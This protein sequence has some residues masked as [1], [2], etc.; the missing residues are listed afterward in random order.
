MNAKRLLDLVIACFGMPVLWAVGLPIALA[1]RVDSPGKAIFRQERV[2]RNGD[3]FTLYKFR[4][5]HIGTASVPTHSATQSD[6]TRVGEWLRRSKL[7]ELPQLVNV[8]R[9]DM[10]LVG[11]RPCLPTQVDLIAARQEKSVD[12][13]RPGVTGMAQVA[14]IDMSDPELLAEIDAAYLSKSSVRFDI[15]TI[16]RTVTGSGSGDPMAATGR[17]PDEAQP[18]EN[19]LARAPLAGEPQRR[20]SR[21]ASSA[22]TGA[23]DAYPR[24]SIIT[25]AFNSVDT[26]EHTIAS[27]ANQDYDNIEYIVIDG[28]STDGTQDIVEANAGV[29]DY[30]VSEADDGIYDAMNKGVIASSGA[31]VAILSSDDHYAD[32]SVVSRMVHAMHTTGS[33]LVYADVVFEKSSERGVVVRHYRSDRFDVERMRD[34]LMPAHPSCFVRSAVFDSVGLFRTDYE[35]AADFEWL[36]RA[37]VRANFSASFVDTVAVVMSLGGVST[38]GV[39]SMLT[40]PRE[41]LRACREN[42]VDSN[43]IRHARTY[44]IKCWEFVAP[45]LFADH[46]S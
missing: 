18:S 23:G 24:V 42:G 41:K 32:D 7:D 38:S 14:G 36:V 33:D 8:L 43:W 22:A 44:P 20:E 13:L 10:S 6:V 11:P 17:T 25:V 4:T 12:G 19:G 45:R 31:I 1:I 15:A 39:S 26:I 16:A 34:G 37:L 27:V 35:I 40:N 5:M 46:R 21:G 29:V 28:G 2:G 30:F 9:G 3:I